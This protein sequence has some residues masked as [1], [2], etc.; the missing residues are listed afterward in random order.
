ML[1]DR[2]LARLAARRLQ[3]GRHPHVPAMPGWRKVVSWNLLRRVGATVA[4]IATLI[5]HEQPDLVLMQEATRD[6]EGLTGKVGG[7][8]AWAQLPGRIHGL[9]I[10]SRTPFRQ[11]PEIVALPSGALIDRVC[12]VLDLGE[13]GIANVHLSH[14]QVLNRRQLRRIVQGLPERAA[15]IGDYN[16]VGPPLLPGF[17]DVGPRLATHAMARLVPLRLDRCLVRGLVCQGAGVLPRGASD[18]RPIVMHLAPAASRREDSSVRGMAALIGRL[19]RAG[20]TAGRAPTDPRAS[21][22]PPSCS[23]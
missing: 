13:F 1:S 5:E 11:A 12:Q 22:E 3:S 23:A 7:D 21:D 15:V 18:H 19:R 17:R 20:A 2:G 10:W 8:Y 9:A 4:G 14:G 6:I 16:L